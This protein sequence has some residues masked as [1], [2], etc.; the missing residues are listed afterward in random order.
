MEI[1]IYQV[2]TP[3]LSLIF[4]LR[5]ISKYRREERTLREVFAQ[6]F[7]W[8]GIAAI[9]LFPDVAVVFV[10]RFTGMKSGVTGILFLAILILGLLVIY[11]IHENEKRTREITEIVR[12]LALDESKSSKDEE[13]KSLE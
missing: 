2:L 1:A 9:S 11:L 10:E 8:I 12:C 6:L 5:V 3:V 7:F 13:S 4:I